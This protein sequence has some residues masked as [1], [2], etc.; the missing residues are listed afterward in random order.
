[1]K[2]QVR[3]AEALAAGELKDRSEA[4]AGTRRMHQNAD[5]HGGPGQPEAGW[6]QPGRDS[7]PHERRPRPS[8]QKR[9]GMTWT[10]GDNGKAKAGDG[11]EAANGA[12][13][14]EALVANRSH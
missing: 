2:A 7:S 4:G 14:R 8:G 5:E 13:A 11:D 12:R 10:G 6:V 3:L 1:M 9:F